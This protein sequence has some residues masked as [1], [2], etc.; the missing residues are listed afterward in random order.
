[1]GWLNLACVRFST[2]AEGPGRRFA[3]WVQGCTKRCKG[4]CNPEMQEIRPNCVVDTRDL[5]RLIDYAKREHQ[6]E[7][8]TFVGGEPFLQAEGCG[9]VAAW[10]RE[11]GLS[12]LTF[13]GFLYQELKEI[14][15]AERFLEHIDVLVD[16]P[17]IQEQ[18][19]EKRDWIGSANQKVWYLT[20]RYTPEI[21]QSKGIRQTEICISPSHVL[22]NGWPFPDT[23]TDAAE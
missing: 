11:N 19:E 14:K 23:N 18:Y 15:C 16:G 10:C 20:D 2:R 8:I 6:I 9:E 4:C 3:I 17:F 1:M 21:E 22:I 13:S 12:V 7:G 5:I